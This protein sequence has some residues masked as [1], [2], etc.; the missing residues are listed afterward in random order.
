MSC[1]LQSAFIYLSPFCSQTC[2]TNL[3]LHFIDEDIQLVSCR[4]RKNPGLLKT[5]FGTKTSKNRYHVRLVTHIA[6]ISEHGW[7]LPFLWELF[8]F[9]SFKGIKLLNLTML[10]LVNGLTYRR[11][12]Y[13]VK[14]RIT[15]TS[16]CSTSKTNYTGTVQEKWTF[17]HCE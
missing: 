14:T 2:E 3:Y 9:P 17:F 12:Y 16:M 15:I 13:Q 4:M 8:Y 11:K 5:I 10:C 1:S 6:V 7:N